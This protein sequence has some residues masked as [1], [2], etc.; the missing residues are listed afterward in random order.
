[1]ILLALAAQLAAPTPLKP[2]SWFTELDIPTGALELKGS[3]VVDYGIM[4]APDG[5]AQNCFVERGT[6]NLEMDRRVCGR[7]LS[8]ARFLPARSAAGQPAYGVYRGRA[9]WFNGDGE[10]PRATPQGPF[11]LTVESLPAKVSAPAEVRVTMAVDAK[12]IP[13]SCK[14]HDEKSNDALAT[15]ACGQMLRTYTAV[16]ARDTA[17]A[18]VASVQSAVVRFFKS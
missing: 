6:G 11:D 14:P 16:P 7:V 3:I 10:E 18:P 12:G 17:G 1:M 15:A 13:T 4:V 9:Q 8:H 5:T 2:D